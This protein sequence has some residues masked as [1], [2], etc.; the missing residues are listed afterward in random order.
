M[1]KEITFMDYLVILSV[2]GG[3]FYVLNGCFSLAHKI[4]YHLTKKK[5]LITS[6]ER[7]NFLKAHLCMREELMIKMVSRRYGN[8]WKNISYSIKE[9]KE[10]GYVWVNFSFFK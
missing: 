4:M 10:K 3:F 7:E 8:D 1:T 9:M 6:T 2:F 5:M